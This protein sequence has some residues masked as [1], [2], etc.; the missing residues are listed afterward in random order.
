MAFGYI[1]S[2]E[3]PRDPEKK[4]MVILNHFF[5]QDVRALSY[6]QS[7]LN[8]V[9]FKA[10][11]LFKGARIFFSHGVKDFEIAY[12]DENPA[13]LAEYNLECRLMFNRIQKK[14]NPAVIVITSDIFYWVREFISIA[15]QV[16]VK[17]VILDKEG[18][19]SEQGYDH[20]A[21]QHRTLA[22][23]MADHIYV[24]S[25]RQKEFWIKGGASAEQISVIGQPRSDLFF[26][27]KGHT[28]DDYFSEPKPLIALFSYND[29]AYMI[30]DDVSAGL[31]W[32]EMKAQTHDAVFEMAR[33]H[34]EYNFVI[35]THPQQ[36]DL[37]HLQK[38]YASLKNLRVIG[39]SEI[40]NE[41]VRR[42]ELIIGFQTTALIEALFLNKRVI[43]TAWDK[44]HEKY[45]DD[46]LP[47]HLSS[48]IKTADTYEQFLEMCNKFFSGD[49]EYFQLT[50]EEIRERDKFVNRYFYKPDGHV[51]ERFFASVGDLVK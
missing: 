22:P 39:G 17:T 30:L 42:P 50:A 47:L 32:K 3:P 51:C 18:I 44:N 31:S 40:A 33:E 29:T 27:E 8:V 35:K 38:R 25:E 24:Y 7:N 48:G 9:E 21:W 36:P 10:H 4:S 2:I 5:D 11:I 26:R 41:L 19:I 49:L 6:V 46:I 12:C 13:R 15:H 34:P 45:K 37:P 28:V 23:F 16:G 20:I 14:F 1:D 43:Y